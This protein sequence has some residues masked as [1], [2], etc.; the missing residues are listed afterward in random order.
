[1]RHAEIAGAGIA[2]LTV[3]SALA[4]EGW[5]VR[6]HE[7]GQELRE[8]GAGIYVFENGLR[9]LKHIGAY[10]EITQASEKIEEGE[11]RDH[12]GRLLL[13]D[14]NDDRLYAVVRRTL[15]K[16]L[17]K[18]AEQKGVEIR[19]NS[20]VLGATPDGSI[21][22]ETGTHEADLVIGADGVNSRVRDSLKLLRS[23]SNLQ[24][25]CG[26]HL[27]ERN[28]DDRSGVAVETWNGGRRIGIVPCSPDSTYLF[29]CCPAEDV[30]G[31]D[32][33]P[34]DRESWI[35]S[36]PQFESQLNRIPEVPEGWYHTFE[37]L[38]LWSWYRGRVAILGDAAHGM[39]PNLGQAACTAMVNGAALARA[40]S[41]TSVTDGLREWYQ[42]QSGPSYKIQKYSRVYGKIGTDWPSSR[43]SLDIRSLLVRTLGRTRVV[44]KRMQFAPGL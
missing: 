21:I 39:S 26:R 6:V 30:R 36:F 2:G 14:R 15:H 13:K 20:T 8:I 31:A 25:G 38:S 40:V 19:T 29:L 18:T 42:T 32:Q 5:S 22:T 11:L 44:Q 35:A 7:R 12:R 17:A 16:V 34:F 41:Q 10:D 9:V 24:D 4:Q 1:M 23:R 27:I 43:P 3:A 37:D 33:Q 28:E